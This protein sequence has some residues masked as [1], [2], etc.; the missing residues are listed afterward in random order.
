MSDFTRERELHRQ[1]S[2]ALFQALLVVAHASIQVHQPSLLQQEQ[3]VLQ[4]RHFL[5][6]ARELIVV[7]GK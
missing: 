5:L 4:L 3:R 6:V 7:E 2:Q 1:L